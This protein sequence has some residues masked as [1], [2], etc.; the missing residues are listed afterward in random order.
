MLCNFIYLFIN[1]YL[2]GNR[3]SIHI[4]NRRSTSAA[5][6]QYAFG[7]RA[8]QIKMWCNKGLFQQGYGKI[9]L[10]DSEKSETDSSQR[11]SEQS[12]QSS[13]KVDSSQEVMEQIN[14]WDRIR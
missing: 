3:A 11:E 10:S 14:P 1:I 4:Y 7:S 13:E 8:I 5:V 2:L 6:Y 9:L 12:S